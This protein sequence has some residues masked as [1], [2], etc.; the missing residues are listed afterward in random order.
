MN[1]W[2]SFKIDF[3]NGDD[4]LQQMWSLS[5]Y[6]RA[7]RRPGRNRCL[8]LR[9]DASWRPWQRTTGHIDRSQLEIWKYLLLKTKRGVALCWWWPIAFVGWY[10]LQAE[11]C[12]QVQNR[13]RHW[14]CLAVEVVRPYYWFLKRSLKPLLTRWI[15]FFFRFFPK[16]KKPQTLKN[17]FTLLS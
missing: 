4:S 8:L 15:H 12:V 1:F 17:F 7:H 13:S 2:K 11:S 3:E 9:S 5:T 10:Y 14:Y 6:D 16:V